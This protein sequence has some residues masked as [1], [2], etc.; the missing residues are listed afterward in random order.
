MK[1]EQQVSQ[2]TASTQAAPT[3]LPGS[4]EAWQ[5]GENVAKLLIDV[6]LI[7]Q[8]HLRHARRVREK[9][10]EDYPLSRALI[11]LRYLDPVKFR[12]ALREHGHRVNLGEVM[13]ELGYLKPRDFRAALNTQAQLGENAKSLSEILLDNGLVSEQRMIEVLSDQLGFSL[14]APTFS[15]IDPMLLKQVTPDWCRRLHAI[16]VRQEAEGV[17]V[18]FA[19]PLDA[20]ARHEAEAAFEHVNVIPAFATR[21]AIE[22]LLSD[23]EGNRDGA[24]KP[25]D[26]ADK[27]NIGPQVEAL[28]LSA[29]ETGASK[30]HIEPAAEVAR[31]RFRIEGGLTLFRELAPDLA[32]GMASWLRT[33][34]NIDSAF[35]P[36]VQTESQA[37]AKTETKAGIREGTF[38]L[39]DPE[40]GERHAA[41]LSFCPTVFG[42]KVV[43]HLPSG[44]NARRDF[45]ASGIAP[46]TRERFSDHALEL[47][48]GVILFVGPAG[49]G[50]T[51]TLYSC[52]DQLK[53]VGTSISTLED[54]VEAVIT[55]TAQCGLDQT[56][57]S[58]F[59]RGMGALMR[60]DPDVLVVGEMRE[61][62]A[63]EAA[64]QAALSGHKVLSTFNAED[65]VSALLRLI[66]MEVKP[67][68][69]ASTVVGV[70]AQRLLRRVCDHC[71]ERHQPL[72]RDLKRVGW[73]QAELAGGEF[74]QGRGCQKC[75]FSGYYGRIAVFELLLP[76]DGIREALLNHSFS[77]K[78]RGIGIQS[79]GLVTL[80]EDGLAK[81]GQGL[82]SL[83]EVAAKLPRGGHPRAFQEIVAMVGEH[84]A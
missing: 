60:Q 46:R 41:R 71:A 25:A 44:H 34:A 23:Y 15:E 16:P 9:L 7:D 33:L 4:V 20:A 53:G 3:H 26:E 1:S 37:G 67:F 5:P 30:V 72:P 79:A 27:S 66:G 12:D 8:E 56:G 17:W 52:I 43:I 39:K 24:A 22:H 58:V 63:A 29:L 6:G 38:Q 14:E 81:A 54:P 68:L 21:R 64:M 47:P 75:N 78:I 45:S 48:G 42:D 80:L 2:Q 55:G 19:D 61:R 18:V 57:T 83:E 70:L 11:E 49:S 77:S 59:M 13:V 36:A 28:I 82:T 51:T 69:L 74:R 62:I 35:P 50:K 84:N 40:T 10:D 65:S 73:T 76:N 32:A 31:V